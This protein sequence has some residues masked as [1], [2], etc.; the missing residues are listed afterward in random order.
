MTSSS[1]YYSRNLGAL[2]LE[3]QQTLHNSRVAVVGCG[4]LGGY[5]IE[6]LVRIGVGHVDVFDPDVFTASNCNRQLNALTATFGCNKAEVAALRS[7][8]IHPLTR[9]TPWHFDF[10]NMTEANWPTVQAVVD[11]LD[12]VEARK[13]LA[14]L[15][16]RKNQ[17]LIHGAVNAWCGQVG[18]QRPGDDLI[19]RLYPDRRTLQPSTSLPSV[20]VCTVVVVAGL[21]VG[22]TVKVLLGLPSSLH[23]SWVH[24]DLK[25]GDC[26]TI[27]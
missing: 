16:A 3:Q 24:I 20:L 25:H 14:D 10:R 21:Q 7:R 5:V 15:C 11:C 23:N 4:G 8:S 6:Q 9:V 12:S 18:V 27:G 22:E 2:T 17:P 26:A 13:D 1:K 19:A